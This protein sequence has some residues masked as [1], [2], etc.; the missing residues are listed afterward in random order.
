[1][2]GLSSLIIGLSIE[3]QHYSKNKLFSR[4]VFVLGLVLLTSFPFIWAIT[5]FLIVSQ[6]LRFVIGPGFALILTS[7]S[8]SYSMAQA[9]KQVKN[10]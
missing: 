8:T 7:L 6:N 5:E 9:E 1:L 2:I 4:P 10:K 3:K